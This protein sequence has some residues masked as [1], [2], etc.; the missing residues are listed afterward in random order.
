MAL[1]IQASH[2]AYAYGGNQIFTDVTFELKTGDRI[3]L[4]GANG[5]GKSTLFRLLARELVPQ[6]GDVVRQ[7]GITIGYLAQHD[8]LD[9]SLSPWQLVG[10]V[11]A[12]AESLERELARLEALLG[13][14]LGDDEMADVI[15]QYNRLL[16]QLDAS[17][18]RD[19]GDLIR[20][21]LGGL[22]IVERLWHQP[23]GQMSGGERKLVAL[24]R[25]LA[26]QPDVLLLDEPDNHLDV[27]A[28]AWLE[29][30][31]GTYP[32]VVGL[33]THDRY[34]IDRVANQIVELEDGKVQTYPG[35][36]ST[37]VQ[38]KRDRLIRQAQLRELEE[39]EYKKLKASAEQLTQWARQNPK[40]ASRAENQRRKLEEERARLDAIPMPVLNRRAIEVEFAA[41]RGG[42]QVFTA[43]GVGKAYGDH[44]VLAPFDLS[45]HHAERVALVGPNGSGKTTLF[46]LIQGFELPDEGTVRLGASIRI[47]Y[48]SQL[49][50][51]IDRRKTPMDLVRAVKP[52]NE[53]QAL[54]FLISFL[55]D[56][57]DTLRPTGELSGG[58]LARLQIALLILSG[59]NFLLLDEPTN[60][61]DINSVEILEEA[62]LEFG[63]TILAISHDR[64]FLDKVCG[65]TITLS[66]GI[67]RD[68]PGSYSWSQGHVALGSVLTRQDEK[69]AASH[70]R[71]GQR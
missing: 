33:I 62:L 42:T 20:Q 46:R 5:T 37:F 40:F 34:M 25:F 52:L 43:D 57:D 3:A 61:L 39:R 29:S 28:R 51:T 7:R 71:A 54:G 9:G 55:F 16:E 47:G 68:Y 32:G 50:E 22:G 35:N 66:D 67:L 58:E 56:R 30:F 26:Q 1:L 36:Y 63:G 14:P 17:D 19:P 2:V 64:Y 13:E 38:T 8:T 23:V 31:L 12:D 49:L 41:E 59:A 24:A 4:V 45:I 18:A 11:A 6:G 65:R 48:F 27:R 70:R 53:Q 60:N 21:L 69:V 44:V 10:D 15:D